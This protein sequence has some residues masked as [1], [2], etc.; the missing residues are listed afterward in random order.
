[1][2]PLHQKFVGADVGANVGAAVGTCIVAKGAVVAIVA[3]AV[4]D[5]VPL[6]T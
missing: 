5:A 4:V 3:G 2:V 1:M 6:A